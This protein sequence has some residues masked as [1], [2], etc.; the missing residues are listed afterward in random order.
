V[1]QSQFEEAGCDSLIVLDCPSLFV[2][3]S[4]L[5]PVS[6]GQ[7]ATRRVITEVFAARR[8][9]PN[10]GVESTVS[11]NA[12]TRALTDELVSATRTGPAKI[13]DLAVR[14]N[15]R[16]SVSKPRGRGRPPK[17]ASLRPADMPVSFCLS[18]DK[19]PRTIALYPITTTEE[20]QGMSILVPR[21]GHARDHG[22][23]N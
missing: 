2:S 8:L 15:G 21:F 10:P 16:L 12:F 1:V 14:L 4:L 3:N 13:S 7:P 23:K 6:V 9:D 5:S 17:D 20:P 11:N 19:N 18:Q 22:K